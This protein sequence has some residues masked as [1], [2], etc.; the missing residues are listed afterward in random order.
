MNH[1]NYLDYSEIHYF[2]DKY[3]QDGNDYL[4]LHH[5][6]IIGHNVDNPNQTYEFLKNT[7]I[8]IKK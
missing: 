1:I 8:K 5:N 7:L 4:L 3:L 2:G 6:D